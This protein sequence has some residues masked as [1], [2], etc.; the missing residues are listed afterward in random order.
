MTPQERQLV[1][2]LFDRLSKIESAPRDPDATAAIA[3]GLRMAPNA[4]YPLVQTVL[5]QDE[6]KVVASS[7]RCAAPSL[8]KDSLKVLSRMYGPRTPAAARSGTVVRSCSKAGITSRAGMVNPMVA[9]SPPW[10][11]E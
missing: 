6:V 10:A 4:I 9:S 1:D 3:Q 8:D 11:A 2:D 5:V 7:I